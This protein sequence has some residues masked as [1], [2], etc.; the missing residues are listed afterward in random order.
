MASKR[1]LINMAAKETRAARHNGRGGKKGAFSA[2]HNDRNFD[3]NTV[4]H[5]DPALTDLNIHQ[6]FAGAFEEANTNEEYELAFY[7]K[8]FRAS[9][10]R[11]NA[12]YKEK[13]KSGQIKTM[14]AYHRSMKSC[15]EETYYT[16]G[17]GVDRELLWQIYT[18]HQA[19]KAERFPLCQTLTA[20]L[21]ADEPNAMLHI[22]ERSVWIGHD[23]N[24]M[25]VVGQAKA[26]TEMGVERPDP[27]KK[28]GK[29]N[30]AKQTFTRECRENFIQI[31]QQHGLEIIVEAK[32]SGKG[33]LDLLEYKIQ[34]AQ[35]RAAEAAQKATEA[36]QEAVE[37]RQQ[38]DDA[39][40]K[41]LGIQEA[42]KRLEAPEEVLGIEGKKTILGDKITLEREEYETLRQWANAGAASKAL[43]DDV[44]KKTKKLQAEY[45]RLRGVSDENFNL[46]IENSQL[47]SKLGAAEKE[48]ESWR[49]S[50]D[51]LIQGVIAQAWVLWQRFVAAARKLNP[52][53]LNFRDSAEFWKK[54]DAKI[55]ESQKSCAPEI[56]AYET[57]MGGGD[58]L[59][60]ALMKRAGD[61][62][63]KIQFALQRDYPDSDLI[64]RSV[65]D[66]DL[67]R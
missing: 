2:K 49:K 11:K 45:D 62:D 31:C 60:A 36:H 30:N 21:H 57:I 52:F 20:D 55:Y 28:T 63:E 26:L 17:T 32:P 22:H 53:V 15:P 67:D 66:L 25:E 41:L 1:G 39:R 35:E 50:F 33:G 3:L 23:S 16:A 46:R 51:Q 29:Y 58:Q 10:D 4:D 7:E 34:H 59:M 65:Y 61:D 24:G 42:L 56:R 9:L 27:S 19:W 13:G 40:G 48:L 64:D 54:N 5:I 47:K 14:E 44:R 37:A 38:A 6:R 43:A 8:H 18:Q 12:A